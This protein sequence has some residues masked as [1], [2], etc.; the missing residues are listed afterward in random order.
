MSLS[1]SPSVRLALLY[2]LAT[3]LSPSVR[4]S[5]LRQHGGVLGPNTS[6]TRDVVN[7]LINKFQ[8]GDW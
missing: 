7:N 6:Q 3:I 8:Y 5:L 2:R 4:A 1:P